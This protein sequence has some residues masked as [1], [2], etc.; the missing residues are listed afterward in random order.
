MSV[1]FLAKFPDDDACLEHLWRTRHAPD[2]EHALCPK[3]GSRRLFKHYETK[4]QRQSWTC[5]GCG[6]HLSAKAG[7]VFQGSSVPLQCWFEAIWRGNLGEAV[8]ARALERKY[9]LSYKAAWRVRC[10]ATQLNDPKTLAD[11]FALQT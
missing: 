10:L 8:S 1:D 6:H 5:T 11:A 3:C 9:G 7:T 2:G 4:Q